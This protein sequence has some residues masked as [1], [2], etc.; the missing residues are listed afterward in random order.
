MAIKQYSRKSSVLKTKSRY[1]HGGDTDVF[2]KRL[3]WWERFLDIEKNHV[4]DIEV[5]ITPKYANRPDLIAYDYYKD[6]M[7]L[8]VVLQYNDIVDIKEELKEGV[9]ITIPSA[10]RVNYTILTKPL[11]FQDSKL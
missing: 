5:L 3:G 2:K 6:A 11:K 9:T 7:L 4:S 1:V 8:W 10:S